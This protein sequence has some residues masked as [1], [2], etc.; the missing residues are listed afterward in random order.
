M[1]NST[2]TEFPPKVAAARVRCYAHW[3]PPPPLKL[4][5][6]ADDNIVLPTTQSARPGAYRIWPY[7]CEPLEAIGARSPEY[8]QY[9]NH[10]E[11]VSPRR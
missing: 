7:L 9:R 6:W 1:L 5:E 11:L 2:P 8:G 10:R 3:L 4:V